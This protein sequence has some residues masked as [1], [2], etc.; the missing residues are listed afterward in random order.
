MYILAALGIIL[1][2]CFGLVLLR[3]A[4]YLPTLTPQVG[5]A[6]D[7]VDLKPG[8]TLLELGCGDG[9]IL[10]AAAKRG[11]NVVGY[12]LNPVMA[13]IAWARTLRYRDRVRVVWGDFWV[14]DWPAADGIFVFLLDRYMEKLNTKIVQSYGKSGKT[15]KLVSFAFHIPSRK[16]AAEKQGLFLYEYK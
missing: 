2:V 13:F 9:K 12:E 3:G 1:A 6:L 15:I 14:V 4:P 10:I 5:T 8:Q 7:L 11:I 16:P